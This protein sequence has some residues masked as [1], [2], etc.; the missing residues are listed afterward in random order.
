MLYPNSRDPFN[1][2]IESISKQDIAY[3]HDGPNAWRDEYMPMTVRDR[4]EKA[5]SCWYG[6]HHLGDLVIIAGYEKNGKPILK[7]PWIT[8]N[9]DAASSSIVG[10]VISVRPNSQTIAESFSRAAAFT[11]DS[12]FYG[13]PE[14]YYVDRGMDY[15][16]KILEGR[17]YDMKQ[18][19]D[20]HYYL[21]RAFCDNPLL[22][23]LNVTIHHALPRSGRSKSIEHLFGTVTRRFFQEIPGWLGNRPENCP[24]DWASEEKRLIKE[25]K[26]W[27]LEKFARYWFDV[28]V[29]G[30]IF[31]YRNYTTCSCHLFFSSSQLHLGLFQ[32]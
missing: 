18:R 11:V 12:P 4:P 3:V 5:N 10:S 29:P 23:A 22:P 2:Y 30:Y 25:G 8:C 15:R 19:I 32:Y 20:Q 31:R 1:R 16:S 14:V 28:V 17:D 7:R 21:N 26:L 27:T 24:F 9:H 13:L 6:D